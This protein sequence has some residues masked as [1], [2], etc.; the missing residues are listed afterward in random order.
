MRPGRV[1][2]VLWEI[3]RVKVRTVEQSQSPVE[4]TQALGSCEGVPVAAWGGQEDH[5][6]GS[7]A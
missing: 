4:V 7:E 3:V 2:G 1:L 5:G 6:V